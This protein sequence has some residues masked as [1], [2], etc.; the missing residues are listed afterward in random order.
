MVPLSYL[1]G[2][3]KSGFKKVDREAFGKRLLHVKGRRNIRVQQVTVHV[4]IYL[5]PLF[6]YLS[7][8]V[9]LQN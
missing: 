8:Q 2:G 7:S 4:P 5:V 3:I 9:S 6:G 1:E